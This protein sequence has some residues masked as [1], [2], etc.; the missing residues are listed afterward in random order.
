MVG[1]GR[2]KRRKEGGGREEDG[3][4]KEKKGF[5][6]GRGEGKEFTEFQ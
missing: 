4:G 6:G 3:R 1:E 2:R 5:R